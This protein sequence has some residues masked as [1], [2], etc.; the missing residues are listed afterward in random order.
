MK[1]ELFFVQQIVCKVGKQQSQQ[2]RWPAAQPSQKEGKKIKVLH[3]SKAGGG[4][5]G[6]EDLEIRRL[7]GG[8]P[9]RAKSDHSISVEEY[10]IGNFFPGCEIVKMEKRRTKRGVQP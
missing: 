8:L 5:L 3:R 10:K 2:D 6:R 9:P 7:M 1:P 4:V